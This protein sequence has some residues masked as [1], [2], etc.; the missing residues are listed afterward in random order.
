MSILLD[1]QPWRY[2]NH[3]CKNTY[4]MYFTNF[5]VYKDIVKIFNSYYKWMQA[6]HRTVRETDYEQVI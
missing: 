2:F 3:F 5:Y 1:W 4:A 6:F